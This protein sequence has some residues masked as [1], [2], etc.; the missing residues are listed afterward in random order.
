MTDG[1]TF[2]KRGAGAIEK[3]ERGDFGPVVKF[4]KLEDGE[5]TVL[6]FLTDSQPVE[7]DGVLRG[8]WLPVLQ[9]DPLPTRAKPE[10][11]ENWPAF[12]GAP[13]RYADIFGGQYADCIVCDTKIGTPSGKGK[14]GPAKVKYWS[15]AAEREEYQDEATGQRRYRDKLRHY[16]VKDEKTGEDV[17]KSERI[18]YIVNL[19]NQNFYDKLAGFASIY[20]TLLDRDY[21]VKRTGAKLDTDYVVAPLDPIEKDGVRFD[22]RVPEHMAK[23]LPAALEVG[24]AAASDGYL[25]PVISERSSDQFYNKFWGSGPVAQAGGGT[26]G[27]TAAPTAPETPQTDLPT[28]QGATDVSSLIDRMKSAGGPPA[29]AAAQPTPPAAA[30]PTPP[31]APTAPTPPASVE[32]PA[33]PTEPALVG[34]SAGTVD[35]D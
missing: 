10:G 9:H 30:A 24:S 16:T 28:D 20:G 17:E 21:Y 12:M 13:C 26:G 6:R 11:V 18:L 27:A 32:T 4:F 15:V 23:Y 31:A 25:E 1:L 2:A 35:F 7:V 29:E 14:V 5:A 8:G 33:A 3:K 22:V 19:S 34:A